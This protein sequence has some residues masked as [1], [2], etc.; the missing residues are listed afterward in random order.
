[1]SQV[2][3]EDW[4]HPVMLVSV[5]SGQASGVLVSRSST[6][7]CSRQKAIGER[8]RDRLQ[9]RPCLSILWVGY[10][11]KVGIFSLQIEE[12]PVSGSVQPSSFVFGVKPKVKTE[13][14]G[15]RQLIRGD[16]K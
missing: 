9:L 4:K 8:S 10:S 3:F 14:L 1:M 12:K 2:C 15:R 11:G 7:G 16:R 5:V 6:A 13:L